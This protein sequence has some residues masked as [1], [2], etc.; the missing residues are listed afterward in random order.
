MNVSHDLRTPLTTIR[1]YSEALDAGQI[2]EEDLARVVGVLHA[3]TNRLSRLVEDVMLLARLEAREFTLR[4]ESVDLG[5]HMREVVDAYRDRAVAAGVT[6]DVVDDG[7]GRVRVDPD[8]IAQ[9]GANLIDNALRFTP[10]GGAVTVSLRPSSGSAV[11]AVTDSGPGIDPEDL[12][13]VFDRLVAANQRVPVRPEG[14]GLGLAIVREL[15]EVMGG[16]VEASSPAEGGTC[17]TVVIDR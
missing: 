2:E 5:A 8:R 6:L 11:L 12:P 14:S 9:V 15:V 16:T 3:E 10:E 13:N 4:P 17:F 1:G 7:V